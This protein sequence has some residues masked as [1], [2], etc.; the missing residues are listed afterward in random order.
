[1][2]STGHRPKVG[3]AV[4]AKGSCPLFRTGDGR[5]ESGVRSQKSEVRRSEGQKSDKRDFEKRDFE[6][7]DWILK[8]PVRFEKREIEIEWEGHL[9]DPH[10]HVFVLVQIAVREEAERSFKI[11]LR[12]LIP[13][14]LPVLPP[15]T[16]M[17]TPLT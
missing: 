16:G 1:M 10:R 3:R 12:W 7:Q 17:L 14:K 5:Q 8:P 9:L 6:K 4:P 13:H 2:R 15:S 11:L